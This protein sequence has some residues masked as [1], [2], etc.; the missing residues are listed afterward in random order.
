M[1]LEVLEPYT[2]FPWVF[3]VTAAR[4]VDLD[5]AKL[6]PCQLAEMIQPLALQLA[7]LDDVERA[8]ELKREL[9]ILAA[10]QARRGNAA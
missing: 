10:M 3:V 6:A 4:R 8:F 9:T 7:S 5:P 1:L 2:A